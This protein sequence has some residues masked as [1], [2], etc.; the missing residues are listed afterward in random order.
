MTNLTISSG[1]V[2][3]NRS[4]LSFSL[5]SLMS[6]ATHLDRTIGV[7]LSVSTHSVLIGAF[8]RSHEARIN[9]ALG[10]LFHSQTAY[11]AG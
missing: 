10:D 7:F 3:L 2:A 9:V 1:G 11:A 5:G 6:L 8:P 4:S